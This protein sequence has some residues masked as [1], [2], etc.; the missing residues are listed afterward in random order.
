MEGG[1]SEPPRGSEG[2]AIPP[3]SCLARSFETD[4]LTC[5]GEIDKLRKEITSLKVALAHFLEEERA[6]FAE[7]RSLLVE[8]LHVN[9][10][11]AAA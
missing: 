5:I 3:E 8:H 6:S 4:G 10:P 1:H 7:L 11:E 2:S 9:L